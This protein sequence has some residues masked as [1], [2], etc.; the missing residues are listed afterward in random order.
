LNSREQ[1]MENLN[2]YRIEQA[3]LI[4][5]PNRAKMEY[6]FKET[7]EKKVLWSLKDIPFKNNYPFILVTPSYKKGYYGI[8]KDLAT[9]LANLKLNIIISPFLTNEETEALIDKEFLGGVVLS[10]GNDIT[11]DLYGGD[12]KS[13]YKSDLRR[14]NF[15]IFLYKKSVEKNLP[16]LAICRGLQIIN[17]AREGTLK[18]GF[19]SH[20]RDNRPNAH[21]L[22]IKNDSLFKK[23]SNAE[24]LKVGTSH[25]Q[26]VGKLGENLISIAEAEDK[27]IEMIELKDYPMIATQF[28]PERSEDGDV[29]FEAFRKLTS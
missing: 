23:L 9:A 3:H 17:I 12:K 21:L 8:W 4:K 18:S 20:K 28:H 22:K 1:D 16:V 29:I 15:E 24:F 2:G 19:K 25:H 27:A 7:E 5:I 6:A 26:A 13:A 14:D 10:G 11:P